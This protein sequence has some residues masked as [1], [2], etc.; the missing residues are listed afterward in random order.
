MPRNPDNHTNLG[1]PL[2]KSAPELF[3]ISTKGL[4]NILG[5]PRGTTRNN[6]RGKVPEQTAKLSRAQRVAVKARLALR[7]KHGER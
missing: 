3:N 5:S 6:T 1:R 2:R 7:C 4:G